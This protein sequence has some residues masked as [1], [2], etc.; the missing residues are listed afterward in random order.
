MPGQG[1]S[2]AAHQRAELRD[3]I[4]TPSWRWRVWARSRR[5]GVRRGL[6]S[7]S[8]TRRARRSRSSRR[9]RRDLA[10]LGE[11]HPPRRPRDRCRS[12]T[13]TIRTSGR[14]LHPVRP[15]PSRARAT[16]TPE[17]RVVAP[18]RTDRSP[19]GTGTCARL[20]VL[21]AR[22][23]IEV[24]GWDS[25]HESIIGSRFEAAIARRD[26]GG[27]TAGDRADH[28]GSGVDHR[29][30]PARLG[31]RRPVEGETDPRS[32]R[33]ADQGAEGRRD[34][35]QGP[36]ADARPHR[37]PR[38]RDAVGSE[39]PLSRGHPADDDD[40]P[41]RGADARDDRS[42]L[43]HGARHRR[44]RL[45]HARRRGAGPSAGSAHVHRRARARAHR[46]TFR[47]APAHRRPFGRLQVLQRDELLHGDRR[48][49][50]RRSRGRARA[51]PPRRRPDQDHGVGRCGEPVR[52]ARQPAVHAGGNRRRR[53]GSLRPSAAT[54]RRTPTRR[55]PS[56]AP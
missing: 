22:G 53:R 15:C 11:T 29:G 26:L 3:R 21:H 28:R 16:V 20:A 41:R 4:S 24:G 8:W 12:S 32:L 44:R 47:R 23:L 1:A 6:C 19:R 37:L 2:G 7:R 10:P 54:R 50:R 52:P 43:H 39:H 9:R 46:R 48:R 49:R 51:A 31:S 42:R 35:L 33:E 5:H 30:V 45:G 13:Q 25:I 55:T 14:E 17:R 18:G 36:H 38:P 40:G 56:R 27:W 34:R